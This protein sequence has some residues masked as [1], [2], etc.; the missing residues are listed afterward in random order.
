MGAATSL[1]A[2]GD[3]VKV[4]EQI[5][6][7]SVT[8]EAKARVRSLCLCEAGGIVAAGLEGGT[9]AA[10]HMLDGSYFRSWYDVGDSLTLVEA[11][12][13][14]HV[15]VSI[16]RKA[17]PE[18]VVL[19][20]TKRTAAGAFQD[21]KNNKRVLA[22][23]QD[24]DTGE[25]KLAERHVV[26]LPP[27][28]DWTNA[29]EQPGHGTP[30]KKRTNDMRRHTTGATPCAKVALEPATKILV[31]RSTKEVAYLCA[32]P[33]VVLY[34]FKKRL[35]LSVVR[36]AYPSADS[37]ATLL[38]DDRLAV[39][40]VGSVLLVSRSGRVT[41]KFSLP[42]LLAR[43]L[44]SPVPAGVPEG[45]LPSPVTTTA[46]EP[47]P[48]PPQQLPLQSRCDPPSAAGTFAEYRFAGDSPDLEADPAGGRA[49]G[50]FRGGND[51]QR[52]PGAKYEAAEGGGREEGREGRVQ[53]V[54]RACVGWD[55][56]VLGPHAAVRTAADPLASAAPAAVPYAR[57]ARQRRDTAALFEPHTQFTFAEGDGTDAATDECPGDGRAPPPRAGAAA[58]AVLSRL[59][60][61]FL[62]KRRPPALGGPVTA[63][64]SRGSVV[65]AAVGQ[66]VVKLNLRSKQLVHLWALDR[67]I[68][69]LV[70]TGGLVLCCAAD[71]GGVDVL[72]SFCGRSFGRFVVSYCPLLPHT[73][74]VDGV[75]AMF[76]ADEPATGDGFR[77]SIKK[78]DL[79]SWFPGAEFLR[80][81]CYHSLWAPRGAGGVPAPPL[82][83]FILS[84]G[85]CAVNLPPEVL[86]ASG[87]S[88]S[89]GPQKLAADKQPITLASRPPGGDY[90]AFTKRTVV[91]LKVNWEDNT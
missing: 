29:A 40:G 74:A 45:A 22:V 38:A 7:C 52:Q 15:Y 87:A 89:L 31:P 34:N 49:G 69:R 68:T 3:D 10:W 9:V 55:G 41:E 23:A 24:E 39:G 77:S 61:V 32:V 19:L 12:S 26:L 73:V 76:V 36:N 6:H 35:V 60:S 71:G 28:L 56:G 42:S 65:F 79:A 53:S 18:I 64:A 21:W 25:A 37:A 58:A 17:G 43:Y 20:L 90:S 88:P 5:K 30:A 48:D 91:R 33:H 75:G 81:G 16:D 62:Y 50:E 51:G 11:R 27:E 67:E 80:A 78:H 44:T 47:A 2:K 83:N 57:G 4:Y 82:E 54:G 72:D 59:A 63:L 84:S 1:R 13:G 14:V 85:P 86:E 66:G 8:I 70:P 46:P